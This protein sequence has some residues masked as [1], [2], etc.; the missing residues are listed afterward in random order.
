MNLLFMKAIKTIIILSLLLI[1]YTSDAYAQ[2]R[3]KDVCIMRGGNDPAKRPYSDWRTDCVYA[4]NYNKYPVTLQFEYKLKSREAPWQ[5]SETYQLA[6]FQEPD[7][8]SI[9]YDKTDIPAGYSEYRLL[10]SFNSEI[11]ALRIVYVKID[12][13]ERNAKRTKDIGNLLIG[14]GNSMNK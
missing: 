8:H 12:H 1:T 4:A 10:D 13:S 3:Y 9:D 14:V 5:M 11:K 6:P 7:Y 2:S